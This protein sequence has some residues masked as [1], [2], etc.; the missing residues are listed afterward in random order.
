MKNNADFARLKVR[1]LIRYTAKAIDRKM[2]VR[3]AGKDYEIVYINGY[4][5]ARKYQE[6]W[7]ER[8]TMEG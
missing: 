5:D 1:F 3:Y 6:L 4:G 7:C 8:L 2:L